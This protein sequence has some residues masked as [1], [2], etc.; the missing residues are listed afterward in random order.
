MW[1]TMGYHSF[2]WGY[3]VSP[4][5][6]HIWLVHYKLIVCIKGCCTSDK[7]WS[8][9]WVE[10]ILQFESIIQ[11]I[12]YP[13]YC[14]KIVGQVALVHYCV[15]LNNKDQLSTS[16]FRFQSLSRN[17]FKTHTHMWNI[18][19]CGQWSRDL[20]MLLNWR[21]ILFCGQGLSD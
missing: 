1:I 20:Q 4:V 17:L 5:S 9:L 15:S 11:M 8:A 7:R 19:F 3:L 12:C 2:S 21:K 14:K 10:F 13:S 16:N 18:V 6:L